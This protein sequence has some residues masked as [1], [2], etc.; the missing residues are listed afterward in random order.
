MV[1]VR[2]VRAVRVRFP[3][4]VAQNDRLSMG[5]PA[6]GV[7][8]GVRCLHRS[9][10]GHQEAK[11]AVFGPAIQEHSSNQQAVP[12]GLEG[13]KGM[14][15]TGLGHAVVMSECSVSD[16]LVA[17]YV[18]RGATVDPP[19]RS[20]LSYLCLRCTM[21]VPCGHRVLRCHRASLEF[22]GKTL[23]LPG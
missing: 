13:I 16:N 14:A 8:T 17:K 20:S 6:H 15:L 1:W 22:R 19:K 2:A 4:R 21:C 7:V 18:C 23:G 3:C 12:R 5:L 11:T 10:H 9:R